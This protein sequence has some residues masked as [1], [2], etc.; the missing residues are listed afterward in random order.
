MGKFSKVIC[1]SIL[2]L[3]AGSPLLAQ[4]RPKQNTEQQT[5]P[6]RQNSPAQYNKPYV[7]L[8]SADGFRYNYMQKFNAVNLQRLSSGGVR[9]KSMIPAFPSL[10][11]PNHYTLATGMYPAHHGLVDNTFFDPSLRRRYSI[12]NI[13]EVTDSIWYGGEPLWVLA[14]KQQLLSAS[15]YWV[16]SEA[17]VQGIRPSYWYH[18]GMEIAMPER[19]AAVRDWLLLPDEKRPHLITFYFPEVDHEAHE[20]GPDAPETAAA[21]QLI[22]QTIGQLQ[23]IID[24][25]K[26]PVNVIF[27]SDHGMSTVDTVNTLQPPAADTSKFWITVGDMTIHLYSKSKN[28]QEIQSQYEQL[29]AAANGYD[30]YLT[31]S[32]PRRWKYNSQNDRYGRIGDILIVPRYPRIFSWGNRRPI[33]GRHGYDPYRHK[34]MHASFYAWGPQ[35]RSG[36]TISTFQNVHVYALI[37]NLLGLKITTPTDSRNALSRKVLQ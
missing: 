16:G 15:F 20:H 7:I 26:L 36:R 32:T 24:S 19:L 8:I 14:E 27:V 2:L 31:S 35:I 5:V 1:W 22:D 34:E 18:Y 23:A 25:S 4:Q 37:T 11:F 30:V 29:K 3:F 21:V 17:P 10:T 6:G 33:P 12:G 28:P 13:K 9:A